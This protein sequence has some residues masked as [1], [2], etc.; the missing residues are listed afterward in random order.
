M[1]A[2]TACETVLPGAHCR[3]TIGGSPGSLA[4]TFVGRRT[5]IEPRGPPVATAVPGEFLPHK[6]VKRYQLFGRTIA[7]CEGD[8][9]LSNTGWRTWAGSWILAKYFEARLG[10]ARSCAAGAV[11]VLDLSCGTGLAGVSLACAGHDAYLCDM[12][13]NVPTIQENL[14]RNLPFASTGAANGASPTG[15]CETDEKT[16]EDIVNNNVAGYAWGTPLPPTLR[17]SFDIVACGDLLYHVWS[18]RLQNE[19][20]STLMDLRRQNASGES[21][22]EFVFGFQVRSGRQENQVLENAAYRLGF[23][24]EELTP[25]SEDVAESP[26]LSHAKYRLVRLRPPESSEE[27]A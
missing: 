8:S 15:N 16:A 18:G 1:A 4:P 9:E 21:G 19:F 12:Q 25:F 2:V 10:P 14:L 22:P 26:L 11:R 3:H 13:V 5:S 23:V 20:I 6:A 7:L 24:I 17:R 27:L